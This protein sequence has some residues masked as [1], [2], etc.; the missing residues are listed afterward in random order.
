MKRILLMNTIIKY[1]VG[2]IIP[3]I[4]TCAGALPALFIGKELGAALERLLMSLAA[5][6]MVAA[7]IWSLLIPAIETAGGAF[8]FVPAV[9]GF[10]FGMAALA[11]LD[12]FINRLCSAKE[13]IQ[14]SHGA[15][16]TAIAVTL[17]NIPEGMAVGVAFAGIAGGAVSYPEALALSIGIAVQNLPEG[18]I[19]SLPLCAGGSRGKSFLYGAA[20]GAVEPAAALITV[21]LTSIFAPALPYVLSF[22]AGA[23]LYVVV[24]EL[25]P[26]AQAPRKSHAVTLG[27]SIGFAIMMLL[28]VV[29]G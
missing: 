27:F 17:H 28:D 21:A 25:I 19:V 8:A 26:E 3:F 16:M 2:I 6:V 5:G 1:T 9:S 29:L 18:A 10:L 7:S 15:L 12:S 14:A 4:G 24:N 22:A 20:S 13:G 11:L 23:M